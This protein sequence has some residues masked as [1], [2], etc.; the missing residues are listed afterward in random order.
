MVGL[1][2]LK[3]WLLILLGS[4]EALIQW[5][6]HRQSSIGALCTVGQV[7]DFQFYNILKH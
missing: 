4:V 7:K 5:Q 6:G 1:D 3:K 2:W